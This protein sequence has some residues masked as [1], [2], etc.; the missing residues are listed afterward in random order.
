M[1]FEV[2]LMNE[3]SLPDALGP[4]HALEVVQPIQGETFVGQAG[5]RAGRVLDFEPTEAYSHY[6]KS[7]WCL[8]PLEGRRPIDTESASS[9]RV[10]PSPEALDR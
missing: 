2:N 1:V 8:L 9:S 7:M 5:A 10:D 3:P 6:P 4:A